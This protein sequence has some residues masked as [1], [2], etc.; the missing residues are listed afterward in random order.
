MPP[1]LARGPVSSAVA[2]V[3]PRQFRRRSREAPSVQ[4]SLARGP[5]YFIRHRLREAPSRWRVTP[6]GK[7]IPK[8]SCKK[9]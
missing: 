3:R 1:S 7:F 8:A 5:V 9:M 6:G 2:R 4:P